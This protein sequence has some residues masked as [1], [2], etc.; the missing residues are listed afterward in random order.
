MQETVV[1]FDQRYV[2]IIQRYYISSP[3]WGFQKQLLAF[4]TIYL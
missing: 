1:R 2:T 4:G 3:Y